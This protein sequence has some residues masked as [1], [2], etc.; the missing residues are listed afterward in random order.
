MQARLK[1]MEDLVL[2]KGEVSPE[3]LKAQKL[4]K[5]KIM[6][7]EQ[8]LEQRLVEISEAEH[9]LLDEDKQNL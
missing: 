5:K 8:L 7:Q 9:Q 3:I 6:K 4:K 2:K 1:E